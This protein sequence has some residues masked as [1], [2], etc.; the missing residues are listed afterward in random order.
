MTVDKE[1]RLIVFTGAGLS[2]DSGIPTFRANT[3]LWADHDVNV[4]A[5]GWTWKNNRETIRK[6]YNDRR[7][8]LANAEPNEAHRLIAKWKSLYN[9]TVLTQ[10]IDNLLERAGCNDVIHLHGELTKMTCIACGNIWDVEYNHVQEEDRCNKCNSLKGVRPYI[11]FFNES[12]PNY[13]KMHAAFKNLRR[14]DCVVVIGTS[15]EVI[16]IDSHLFDKPCTKI[17]NNLESRQCINESYYDHVL[18]GRAAMLSKELNIIVAR[19]F[20]NL[21]SNLYA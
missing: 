8:N 16:N 12:A 1:P 5:N 2:A 17:L 15:G 20:D 10:N 14:E 3:G 4:V 11:V 21:R 13:K 18:F 7:D 6:F 9:T 19:H